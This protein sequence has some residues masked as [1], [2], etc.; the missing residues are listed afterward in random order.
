MSKTQKNRH[1]DDDFKITAIRLVTEGD[2]RAGEVEKELCLFQGA[3]RKWRAAIEPS[4][5]E[6][7]SSGDSISLK[8]HKQLQKELAQLKMENE[9]LKKA[10]GYLA[11]SQ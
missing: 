9:I 3:I 6:F 1:Y 10:M 5:G 4:A 8:D 7:S 2:R 11:K